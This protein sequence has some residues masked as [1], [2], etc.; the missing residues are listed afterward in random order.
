MTIGP[1]SSTKLTDRLSFWW[2]AAAMGALLWAAVLGSKSFLVLGLFFV[3][4]GGWALVR[5]RRRSST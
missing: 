1:V 5:E 2:S 4:Q 3:A